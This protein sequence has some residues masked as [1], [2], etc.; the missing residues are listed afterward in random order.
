MTKDLQIISEIE[1]KL[2]E[3]ESR[4][5]FPARASLEELEK[6]GGR[7]M[8]SSTIGENGRPIREYVILDPTGAEQEVFIYKRES[9]GNDFLVHLEMNTKMKY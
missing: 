9:D 2:L 1:I 7:Y 8:A 5:G 3:I 4:T 6:I